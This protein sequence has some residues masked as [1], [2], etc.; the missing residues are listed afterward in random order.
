MII[1]KLMNAIEDKKERED[2]VTGLFVVLGAVLV[3]GL[4]AFT[5][6]SPF[7]FWIFILAVIGIGEIIF[8]TTRDRDE[9]IKG[10]LKWHTLWRKAE[11][12]GESLIITV[13]ILNIRWLLGKIEWSVFLRWIGYIGAVI[14]GLAIVGGVIYLWVWL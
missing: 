13:N 10:S 1:R 6:I 14:I 4:V 12:I 5:T 9:I 11:S 7:P 2:I 8:W 3:A